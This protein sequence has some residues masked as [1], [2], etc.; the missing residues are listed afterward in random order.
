M[1]CV[2][3]ELDRLIIPWTVYPLLIRNSAR[4]LPSCPLIPVMSAVLFVFMRFIYYF[5]LVC[6]DTEKGL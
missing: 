6:G 4:I 3:S 5:G 1:R 2:L